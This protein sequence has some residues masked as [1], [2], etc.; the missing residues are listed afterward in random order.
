MTDVAKLTG[1][2]LKTAVINITHTQRCRG[3]HE[4]DKGKCKTQMELVGVKLQY[5]N[6]N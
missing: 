5:R 1:K 4:H 3:K 2:G 6:E